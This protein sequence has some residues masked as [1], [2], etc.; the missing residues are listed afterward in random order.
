MRQHPSSRCDLKLNLCGD[1][2]C[3]PGQRYHLPAKLL[4]TTIRFSQDTDIDIQI[5][6]LQIVQGWL[7]KYNVIKLGVSDKS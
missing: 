3:I 6:S 4:C 7:E 5:F 1:V 2:K